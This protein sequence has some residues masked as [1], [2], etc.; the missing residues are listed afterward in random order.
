[1]LGRLVTL[2]QSERPPPGNR[3]GQWV[4][5]VI[6]SAPRLQRDDS[7]FESGWIHAGP[8]QEEIRE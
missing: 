1:M 3:G 6:G 7:R 5:G 8:W 4:H 2:R